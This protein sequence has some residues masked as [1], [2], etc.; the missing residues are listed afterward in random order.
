MSATELW[1]QLTLIIP[2]E[3]THISNITIISQFM[4]SLIFDSKE[5]RSTTTLYLL[6]LASFCSQNFISSLRQAKFN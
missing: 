3:N 2:S 4:P 1:H 6:V 5:K